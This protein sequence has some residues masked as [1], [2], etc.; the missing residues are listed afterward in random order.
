[1]AKKGLK[2]SWK[3]GE[4]FTQFEF[5]KGVSIEAIPVAKTFKK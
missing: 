5:I 3:I 2:R 4:L 1:M